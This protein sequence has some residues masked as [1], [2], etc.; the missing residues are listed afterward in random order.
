MLDLIRAHV[1]KTVG[2][3]YRLKHILSVED[4]C[5]RL[6]AQFDFSADETKDLQ[7]A[8]LLHD[9]TK[10]LTAEEHRALYEQFEL[11]FTKIEAQSPKTLHAVTGAYLAKQIFPDAVNETVFGCILYHTTGRPNMTLPEKL[12]YLADYI[13]PMRTFP[14]CVTLRSAYYDTS[15]ALT[16]EAHLNRI[17]LLSFDLTLTELV[18]AKAYI[19]PTTIQARDYLLAH[20]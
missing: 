12:L 10:A 14:S 1:I 15:D 3:G 4:E 13:E 2:E 16:Q 8:A 20:P 9:L 11:P 6:A 19:H 7:T 18:E 5:L 17:L